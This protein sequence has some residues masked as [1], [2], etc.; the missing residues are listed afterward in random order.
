MKKKAATDIYQQGFEKDVS[1]TG[2]S[3]LSGDGHELNS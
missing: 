3:L 2:Y 1:F